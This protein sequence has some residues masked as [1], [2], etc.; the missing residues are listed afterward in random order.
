MPKLILKIEGSGIGIKTNI[1]NLHDVAK[2]LRVP[3]MCNY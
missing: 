3:T 2:H 1:V